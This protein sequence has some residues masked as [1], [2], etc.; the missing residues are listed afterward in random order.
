MFTI[1]SFED[2]SF[3]M[4]WAGFL[5]EEY[6][7][8]STMLDRAAGLVEQDRI[9]LKKHKRRLATPLSCVIKPFQA[10]KPGQ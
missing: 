5:P 10:Q 9:H 2:T 4:M 1:F 6:G 8:Q 3:L 7:G